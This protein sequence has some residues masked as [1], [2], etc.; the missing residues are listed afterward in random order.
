MKLI[1]D[2]VENEKIKQCF[3][4]N[5][6]TKGV[7]TKGS[8]YYNVVLQDASGTIDGKK[9]EIVE[10]DEA[11]FKIGNIVE[12]EGDV[13]QYKGGNQLKITGAKLNEDKDI[14]VTMFVQ[15]APIARNELQKTLIE[16]IEK[17]S[18]ID[19]KLI[20]EEIIKNNYISFCSY[21]AASKFH[22]E[23]ASGLI[24][25]TVSMLKLAEAICDLYPSLNKSLLYGGVILHD[26][27][28]TIEL[29]GPIVPKYTTQGKLLGHISIIQSEIKRV[30][31]KL[32]IT[33]EVPVLLQHLVLSHHGKH[34]FGSPVL[35][36]IK[37]AEI[38]TYIDNIDSRMNIMDK[39]LS[40]I[41]E[42]EFTPKQ[43]ALEDRQ[44]Y[45]P[46]SKGDNK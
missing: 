27:G 2:F 13:L 37:E 39:A 10:G 8:A 29:S 6:I 30:S 25:H 35:P 20:V 42:G 19:I 16:Y 17:I 12:I 21:P 45:K 46:F 18:D 4:V 34:E 26:V 22:H 33:S 43:L 11:V 15:S 28:K 5:N 31:D 1:K 3:L 41:D 36:M 32:A 38:L 44:I 23:Y 24:H 14:D 40:Q 7:T 9:W